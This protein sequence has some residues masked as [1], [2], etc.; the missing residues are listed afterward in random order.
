MG[1]DTHSM[2]EQA[3]KKHKEEQDAETQK[4]E[5]ELIDKAVFLANCCPR[6][7]KELFNYPLEKITSSKA[8]QILEK[9]DVIRATEKKRREELVV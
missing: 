8:E 6:A 7:Y 2:W 3:V 1:Y 5:K 9:E 4:K